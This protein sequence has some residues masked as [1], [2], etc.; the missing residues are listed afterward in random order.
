[1]S[2]D[3]HRGIFG[4]SADIF[5]RLELD[6]SQ[7]ITKGETNQKYSSA[8]SV[9]QKNSGARGGGSPDLCLPSD[10]PRPKPGP[11]EGFNAAFVVAVVGGESGV[12]RMCEMEEGG[13]EEETDGVAVNRSGV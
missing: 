12:R 7:Q 4:G 2:G 1:M 13:A 11:V 5:Y 6:K 8:A 9:L 10:G 3:K